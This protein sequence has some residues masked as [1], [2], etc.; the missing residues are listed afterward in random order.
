MNRNWPHTDEE[1]KEALT[2]EPP[3]ICP[4]CGAKRVG[5]WSA[6][7]CKWNPYYKQYDGGPAVAEYSCGA[8]WRMI[9]A[10]GIRRDPEYIKTH[11]VP[12][13]GAEADARYDDHER[14][15]AEAR[16]QTE[17]ELGAYLRGDSHAS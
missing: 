9:S 10:T 13:G 5:H 11:C 16:R 1:L 15:V 4:D 2:Y 6:R 14:K 8:Y 7:R 12:G 3:I 17:E